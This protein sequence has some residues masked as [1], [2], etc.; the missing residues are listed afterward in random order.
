[1][2]AVLVRRKELLTTLDRHASKAGNLRESV[3][4]LVVLFAARIQIELLLRLGVALLL[5]VILQMAPG[6][7]QAT[8]APNF[9]RLKTWNAAQ[10]STLTPL[11]RSAT[12][13]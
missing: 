3:R 12:S 1:M 5:G 11:L 10:V 4:S 6:L 7:A 13:V 2:N 9:I 8:E